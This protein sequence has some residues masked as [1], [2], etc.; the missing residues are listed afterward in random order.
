MRTLRPV[1]VL[2]LLSAIFLSAC[3][4][5]DP[6]AGAGNPA[7]GTPAAGTPSTGTPST[8]TPS[9]GTPAAGTP[10]AGTTDNDLAAF[11]AAWTSFTLL[12]SVQPLQ[13]V[14][15]ATGACA[16]GG[17][18]NYDAASGKQ[19][20]Q[21]CRLKQFPGHAFTGAM[22]V[23]ALSVDAGRSHVSGAIDTP[24]IT[25]ADAAGGLEYTLTGGDISSD[26]NDSDAGNQYFYASHALSFT[27]GTSRRYEISNA[28]S[29][30][31][32]IVFES[33]TPVRYTNNLVFTTSNGTQTWQV[34]ATGA[35]REAGD[36]RPDRGSLMITRLG[37]GAALNVTFGAD[38]T[39]TLNGGERGSERTLSWSDA[40]LKAV[41]AASH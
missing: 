14:A 29:T 13:M 8:S 26:V 12:E 41:L 9:T 11:A 22:H 28:G 3:G 1:S 31:T 21:Q 35:V 25:V 16:Q 37:A 18:L 24:G 6:G 7:A 15:G 5:S 36:K 40:T 23:S 10:A 17:S 20:L 19:S 39:L 34:S 4:G 32:A 30:S 33:G 2:M 38:N 27:A